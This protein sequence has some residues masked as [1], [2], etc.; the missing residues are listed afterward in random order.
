MHVHR[1]GDA[2]ALYGGNF[3][4]QVHLEIVDEA[5]DESRPDI[6]RVS[7]EDDAVTHWHSHPGGQRLLVLDGRARIGTEA[8]GELQL[9]PGT[10]V[11]TPPGERHYH[12]SADEAGCTM[13]AITWGTTHWEDLAPPA[14]E[15]STRPDDQT[16]HTTSRRQA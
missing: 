5:A 2:K 9:E 4:G 7:F 13:L 6:A 14:A 1:K 3:V 15:S 8:D 12:G 16:R 11:H 10:F